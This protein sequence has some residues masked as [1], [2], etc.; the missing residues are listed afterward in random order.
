MDFGTVPTSTILQVVAAILKGDVTT[1]TI[2]GL[3]KNAVIDVW[4]EATEAI[5]QAVEFFRNQ[6]RIPVSRLLP[7]NALLVPFAYFFNRHPN[8]PL[9]RPAELLQDFFWR[10]SL[11]ARYSATVEQKLAQDLR[12]IDQIL[13]GEQPHYEWTVDISPEFISRNGYFQTGRSY[14]KAILCLYAYLQPKAFDDNS[15][16]RLS[17]D[18]LKQ[19]N[20]KNYHHVF[21]RAFLRRLGVP[22]ESVNHIANITIV[23]DFLNKR[24]IRDKAP[25]DY[26]NNFKQQNPSLRQTLRDSHLIDLNGSGILDDNY[27]QFLE[28][29]MRAIATELQKRLLLTPDDRQPG[30]VVL[31]DYDTVEAV[32]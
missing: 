16:V 19:A 27:P 24:V 8:K 12:K 26:L 20:S 14:I 4:D 3:E 18:W 11:G 10:A 1:K 17:N 5:K 21:P 2:L 30:T 23:D 31:E 28:T 29:R 15:L 25:S 32:A 9:G 6:Y 22:D 13:R 7:Y